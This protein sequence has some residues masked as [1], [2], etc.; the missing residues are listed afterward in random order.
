MNLPPDFINNIRNGFG[1]RGDAW[2]AALPDLL[3]DIAQRWQLTLL[4]H[5]DDLSY[6]YVAPVI[7]ADGSSAVLKLGVPDKELTYSIEALRYFGGRHMVRLLQA[8]AER[9]IQLL[10]RLVPGAMLTSVKDDEL[11]TRIACELMP[12]LWKPL[13]TEVPFPTISDWASGMKK[14]SVVYPTGSPIPKPWLDRA[15]GLFTDLI[16]LQATP[17]VLH[18][19]LHHYN[20][21]SSGGDWK[22]IDPQGV[23]G[24]PAYETGAFL[25]NPFDLLDHPDPMKLTER[26]IA[27]MSEMLG[28]ERKRILD[29]A[30]AQAVLS[31]WWTIEGGTGT[32]TDGDFFYYEML[33]RIKV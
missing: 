17:V 16:S 11:A 30:I 13:N 33:N 15:E 2:L 32:L 5:F 31:D 18:G 4:P 23:I 14:V 26:R 19:D 22:A 21:L 6:G 3:A 20:I 27:I 25:R 12:G 28:F 9:G 7:C 8:D 10:E 1:A 24:E 29:W